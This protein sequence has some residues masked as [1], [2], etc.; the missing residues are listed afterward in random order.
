LQRI[1]GAVAV[2]RSQPRNDTYQIEYHVFDAININPTQGLGQTFAD[3]FLDLRQTIINMGSPV[4]HPVATAFVEDKTQLDAFHDQ[5]VAE[6]YEGIM[7]RPPGPYT[8]GERT[9]S[10]WKYKHWEDEEFMCCGTTKGDGKA[11]IG[12]GS[13]T[14]LNDEANQLPFQCGTGFTD[15]ERIELAE[16]PPIGKMVKVKFN[17][18]TADGIPVPCVFLSVIP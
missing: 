5:F 11:S 13:L 17:S 1:N 8:P 12:I 7:L 14:L 4:I 2:N 6:G 9:P 10:L 18:K 16:N 15:E 3:R